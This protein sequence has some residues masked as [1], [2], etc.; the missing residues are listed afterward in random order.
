MSAALLGG[1]WLLATKR[2]E[3]T[4]VL[5]EIAKSNDPRLAGLATI[6]LWR[7]HTGDRD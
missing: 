7:K 5:E 3:A 6:Q 2:T 1:S 4:A